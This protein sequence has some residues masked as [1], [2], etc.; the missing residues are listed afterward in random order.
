MIVL[1]ESAVFAFF[2]LGG[3]GSILIFD[4]PICEEK[5]IVLTSG[6]RAKAT[7]YPS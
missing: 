2:L 7:T 1:S 4:F 3:G 6:G 5:N